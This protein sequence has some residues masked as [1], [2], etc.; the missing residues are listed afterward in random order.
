MGD[1]VFGAAAEFWA[2]LVGAVTS[3]RPW[4]LAL[5]AVGLAALA[6]LMRGKLASPWVWIPALAA[7]GLW[8]VRHLP[9]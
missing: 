3:P 9:R 2:M 1:A 5:A 7:A 8:A 6:A 4:F